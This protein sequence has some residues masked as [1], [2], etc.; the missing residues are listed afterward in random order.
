VPTKPTGHRTAH[1]LDLQGHRGARGLRP[2][3]TL[4]SFE[5]ALDVEVTTLELDLHLSSDDQ[6]IIWHD[7][8]LETTKCVIPP[9]LAS[10]KV[11]ELTAAQLATVRCAKN[12]APDRFENQ[13]ATATALAGDNYYIVTLDALF[14]FVDRYATDPTKSES[15]RINAAKIRFNIET[16]R[17]VADPTAIDD[18]FDGSKAGTFE[19]ALVAIIRD[20]ELAKRITVQSFDHRS[21]WSVRAI[22]PDLPLAAL[23]EERTDL[24]ALFDKGAAVWSPD[25]K[26]VGPAELQQAHALGMEIIPWTVN[27][28]ADMR[29]LL[30]LGVDGLI[31]DRPDLMVEVAR[32][33]Q[34]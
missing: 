17:K 7:P 23:T 10:H 27:D 12:P 32:A 16:K 29:A 34:L 9:E 4:P 8:V 3:N 33:Q 30:E 11:R 14:D 1:T 31:S 26:V 18:G 2:E 24:A 22:A 28:P 5:I 19:L 6:L 13:V 15:Q 21:L 25:Y 20:R